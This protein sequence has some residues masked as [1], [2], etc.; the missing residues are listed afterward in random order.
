MSILKLQARGKSQPT[1]EGPRLSMHCKTSP[2]VVWGESALIISIKA[3]TDLSLAHVP[4]DL[5]RSRGRRS[6]RDQMPIMRSR[7]LATSTQREE[8]ERVAWRDQTMALKE[9]TVSVAPM[10]FIF[11]YN[12]SD[13]KG[14]RPQK[15]RSPLNNIFV[16]IFWNIIIFFLVQK[17][18]RQLLSGPS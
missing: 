11:A 10:Q 12:Y 17:C 6:A 8:R 9:T 16:G 18:K 7:M 4:E 15:F 14:N 13:N 1:P 3:R 2:R 5:I